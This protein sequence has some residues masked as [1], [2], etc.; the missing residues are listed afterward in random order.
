LAKLF[1]ILLGFVAVNSSHSAVLSDPGIYSLPMNCSELLPDPSPFLSFFDA[2]GRGLVASDKK[3]SSRIFKVIAVREK[4]GDLVDRQR[5]QHPIDVLVRKTLCFYREQ[6]EPLKPVNYDDP[7]FV[8]YLSQAMPDLE[9]RVGE[10]VYQWELD[11]VQ[12]KQFEKIVERNQHLIQAMKNEAS[13][14]AD[15]QVKNLTQKAKKQ[16]KDP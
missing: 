11:Q 13:Q 6:K 14:K 9:K 15:E 16:V 4:L 7:Q 8:S 1:L 5:D 3:L 2:V 10:V 12:R